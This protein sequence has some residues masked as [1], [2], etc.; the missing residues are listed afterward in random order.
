MIK[1]VYWSSSKIL[2]ILVRFLMK[3]G[4]SRQ[5][6]AKNT[7]ISTLMKILPVG[8]ELFRA[9]RRTDEHDEANNRFM[10]FCERAQNQICLTIQHCLL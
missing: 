1:N 8:A 3:F 6:F 4:F 9:D 7:Q 10:Q 5:V 2:V